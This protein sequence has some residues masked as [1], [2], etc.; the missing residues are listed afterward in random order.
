MAAAKKSRR[1]WGSIVKRGDRYYVRYTDASGKARWK[2]AGERLKDAEATLRKLREQV[3]AERR[4]IAVRQMTLEDWWVEEYVAVLRSRLKPSG[5]RTAR[6]HFQR[7]CDWLADTYGT[8][9]LIRQVDRRIA[10]AFVAD[11]IG[12]G[13]K[14]SYVRR[15]VSTIRRAWQDAITRHLATVNPWGK[16][17]KGG[18]PAL[19]IA[20]PS[21]THVPWITPAQLAAIYAAT[22]ESARPHI[23]LI[24]ETGLRAGEAQGL[25]RR[26]VDLSEPSPR[27]TVR[28]GKTMAARRT[29]PLTQLA[30]DTIKPLVEGDG[31]EDDLVLPVVSQ[32]WMRI[33]L[34]TACE[35]AKCERLVVH[36]LRHVYASHLVQHG[37]PAS[38]V[39]RLL[40]H[41]D[42][43]ALVMRL[44][45]RWMPHDAETRAV[46]SLARMRRPSAPDPAPPEAPESG[47]TEGTP[48]S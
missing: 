43:G 12:E 34:K 33:A 8:P 20:A 15:L 3:E 26:D 16:S 10:E 36:G 35:A 25:R 39:A 38:T 17:D 24:G 41:A 27:V 1:S 14:P 28:D 19:K 21:P 48:T 45:G 23:I 47:A 30:V 37:V 22:P 29:V 44:Y 4:G 7:L 32:Q 5:L 2:V 18:W 9:P 11:L 42:G 40:G 13:L 31:H 6:V 46:Q